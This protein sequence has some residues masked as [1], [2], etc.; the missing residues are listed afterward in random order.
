MMEGEWKCG[1]KSDE[2]EEEVKDNVEGWQMFVI[3]LGEIYQRQMNMLGTVCFLC[4]RGR[5]NIWI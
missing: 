1:K 4:V 3:L 5:V 2:E